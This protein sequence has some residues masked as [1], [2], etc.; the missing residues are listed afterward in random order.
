MKYK[1]FLLFL[2]CIG[3]NRKE[4]SNPNDPLNFPIA[5]E[6]VYPMANTVVYENPPTFVWFSV[7]SLPVV[8]EVQGADNS[9]F[10]DLIFSELF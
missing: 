1:V 8:Y 3:C 5:P 6:P 2:F 7:D 4:F 10:H 9:N